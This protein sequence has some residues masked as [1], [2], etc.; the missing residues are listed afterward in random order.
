MKLVGIKNYISYAAMFVLI[1]ALGFAGLVALD[2]L[3]GG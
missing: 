2:R 3:L 1:A